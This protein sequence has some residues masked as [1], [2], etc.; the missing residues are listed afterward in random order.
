M[1]IV[2]KSFCFV[3]LIYCPVSTHQQHM[4]QISVEFQ[5]LGNSIKIWDKNL[6]LFRVNIRFQLLKNNILSWKQ[7]MESPSSPFY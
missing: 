6:I 2:I 7:V 4:T 3:E 5:V 1:V